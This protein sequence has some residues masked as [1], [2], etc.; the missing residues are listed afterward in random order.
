MFGAR[1]SRTLV[2]SPELSLL[3]CTFCGNIAQRVRKF[4]MY[5]IGSVCGGL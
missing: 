5:A 4:A 3:V 1:V 2:A